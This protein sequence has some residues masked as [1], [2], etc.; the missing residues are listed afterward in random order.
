MNISAK[1]LYFDESKMWVDLI[2]GRTISVPLIWFPR[3]LAAT[4]T[5]REHY[6]ISGTGRGLHWEEIDEDISV[7]AL[8]VGYGDMTHLS[9]STVA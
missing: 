6:R 1:S 7:E 9:H 3:L 5:Q 8:L 2:D 4:P